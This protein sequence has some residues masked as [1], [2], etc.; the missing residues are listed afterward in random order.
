MVKIIYLLNSAF[1][2]L[3]L[4]FFFFL[5]NFAIYV[6]V[7]YEIFMEFVERTRIVCCVGK[8]NFFVYEFI[9]LE[10]RESIEACV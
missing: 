9:V 8:K 10:K 3:S 4:R 7:V 5:F 1:S 2:S 6:S